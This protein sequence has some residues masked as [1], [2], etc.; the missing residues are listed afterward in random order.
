MSNKLYAPNKT[1]VFNMIKEIN[2]SKASTKLASVNVNVFHASVNV[3][4]M[5]ENLIQIKKC[6]VCEKDCVWNPTTCSCENEKY[7]ATMMDDLAIMCDKNIESYDKETR[8][9]QQILL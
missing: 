1:G 4:S 3:N 2:K 8:T 9:I 6:H 7:L 5:E